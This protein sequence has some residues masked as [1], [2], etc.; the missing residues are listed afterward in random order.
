MAAL[1]KR[2]ETTGVHE[3]WL[4]EDMQKK[5]CKQREGSMSRLYGVIKGFL[6]LQ[7][8]VFCEEKR[9]GPRWGSEMNRASSL[10]VS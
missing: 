7:I 9:A 2:R 1:F 6:G 8:M 3:V 4:E 10:Y 5:R